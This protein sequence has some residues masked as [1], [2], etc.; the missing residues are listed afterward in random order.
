MNGTV[1]RKGNSGVQVELPLVNHWLWA[2]ALAGGVIV[3]LDGLSRPFT[4]V[5]DVAPLTYEPPWLVFTFAVVTLPLCLLYASRSQIPSHE[6]LLLWFVLCT[7]TYIKGFAYVKLPGG[8][9]FVTDLVLGWLLYRIFVWPRWRWISARSWIVK[10]LYAF[11]AA[12]TVAAVRGILS[13][14]SILLV[15]RDSA[16]VGY[17]FFFLVGAYVIRNWEGITRLFLFVALGAGL[18]TLHAL[19]WFLAQ[20]G[21]R[22]YIGFGVYVLAALVGTLLLVI[23]RRIPS[24]WGWALAALFFC[25][26]LLANART[27]FVSLGGLALLIFCVGASTQRK[28][29]FARL[30]LAAS[31]AAAGLVSLVLV[32][33]TDAGIAFV[34][35]ASSEL[36]SGTVEYADD[37]T[38][39]FRFLAWAEA[40]AR[41]AVNP[42]LGEGYGVPFVFEMSEQDVRPHNSYLTVLYKMGLLGM[43]PLLMLL[44]YFHWQGWRSFL[45]HRKHKRAVLLYAVL[46]A[47]LAMCMYGGFNTLLESPYLAA[48]FWILMGVG[49]RAMALL[50]FEYG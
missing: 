48:V 42:L 50:R 39:Q 13:G 46:L 30:K 8:P 40:L 7:V 37:A 45:F 11:L 6:G 25:G 1:A 14:H 49:Y 9:I 20:P 10:L 43:V 28:I 21:Q 16:I 31:L 19:S 18:S 5:Q 22:R 38:A 26:L 4:V 29:A 27:L 33:Q 24:G 32:S 47:H 2:V 35:R 36:F 44:G 12:G 15:F 23:N 34:E 3:L 17:A 41:L